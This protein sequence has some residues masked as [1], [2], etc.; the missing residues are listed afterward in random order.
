[1]RRALLACSVLW[2][3]CL[4]LTHFDRPDPAALHAILDANDPPGKLDVAIA[5]GC[6][7]DEETGAASMCERCRVKSAL[8]AYRDGEVGAVL[9]TG[10]A[11]HNHFVEADAMGRLALARGLPPS[12][13]EREPRALT[14]W[15]NLRYSQRLMQRR[16]WKTA[17][18]VSTADHL[19]RA[20]RFAEWYG[21]RA[22]YRACDLDLP[23]DDEMEW[24]GPIV[25]KK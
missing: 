7:A 9:M 3:G 4:D 21:I 11:A 16:G 25:Q 19:P 6:P 8:R 17:L 10:A 24:R 14:T 2:G 22:R 20:K 23:G 15:M 13:L 18:I 5:L 12:A 1:M